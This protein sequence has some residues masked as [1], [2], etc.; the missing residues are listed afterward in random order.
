MDHYIPSLQRSSR[1][2]E[3]IVIHPLSDERY[4]IQ[5]TVFLSEKAA[6]FCSIFA[7]R[8]VICDCV[9]SAA[10]R[11]CG[12][13]PLWYGRRPDSEACDVSS[14]EGLVSKE[15]TYDA[16]FPCQQTGGGCAAST[17][18]HDGIDL[19]EEPTMGRGFDENDRFRLS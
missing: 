16:R 17:V 15:R 10:E 19:R 3:S 18:V 9:N 14:P 12:Q 5:G 6:E 13:L 8:R 4:R 11:L 1:L 2:A 7:H